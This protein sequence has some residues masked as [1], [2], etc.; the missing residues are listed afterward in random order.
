M[1]GL[2][3]DQIRVV[4]EENNTMVVSGER[5]REKEKNV[6]YMKMERR[7]GKYLKKFPLPENADTEKIT[8]VYQDGVL[9]VTV[10]KKPP[11][12]HKQ[13]RNHS[14]SSGLSWPDSYINEIYHIGSYVMFTLT[15]K[16]F[17]FMVCFVNFWV[18][19]CL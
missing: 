16:R 12:E 6:K 3:P 9:T 13:P 19:L 2:K 5:K 4:V 1:P 8:A 15:R 11:P 14:D 10:G 17:L 18:W 7:L